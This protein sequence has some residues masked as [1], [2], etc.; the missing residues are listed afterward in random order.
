MIFNFQKLKDRMFFD[1][2]KFRDK[3]VLSYMHNCEGILDVGCGE[4]RF[5]GN[6]PERIIGID[7]NEKSLSICKMKGYAVVEGDV[8]ALP[9]KNCQFDAVHCAHV[10]EHLFPADAY[11]LLQEMSRVLKKGGVLCLRAPVLY[12][13]FYDN[14][15]HIKPYQPYAVL[16]Y[17]QDDGVQRTFDDMG[18]SYEKIALINRRN[19]F[20]ER[21][22]KG[23]LKIFYYISNILHRFGVAHPQK[24]GYMLVLKKVK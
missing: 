12:R 9:Y 7:Q 18:F 3:K 1:Q 19:Q 5:I 22:F 17:L 2:K 24:T 10:I 14:F 11:K 13:G 6:D 8:T 23:K 20:F 15:T 16:H 21:S 4:G